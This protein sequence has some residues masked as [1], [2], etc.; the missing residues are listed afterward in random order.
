MQF[1]SCADLDAFALLQLTWIIFHVVH[2]DMETLWP[3]P[4]MGNTIS[5]WQSLPKPFSCAAAL[6]LGMCFAENWV[7]MSEA[8]EVEGHWFCCTFS[9]SLNVTSVPV[10]PIHRVARNIE[11]GQY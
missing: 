8:P 10:V 7:P 9:I 2:G 3:L 4:G 11:K 1:D 5:L 6:S